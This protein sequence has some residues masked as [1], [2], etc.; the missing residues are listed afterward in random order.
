MSKKIAFGELASL[1]RGPKAAPYF[2]PTLSVIPGF[3][4]RLF[5][6]CDGQQFV[7]VDDDGEPIYFP[8]IESGVQELALVRGVDQH[9]TIDIISMLGFSSRFSARSLR[10]SIQGSRVDGALQNRV[11]Q[12]IGPPAP[13]SMQP[14][15]QD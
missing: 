12:E 11:R 9:I 1:V 15:P 4:C 8:S 7:V 2:T 10:P 6:A 5:V 14:C 13:R 3:G